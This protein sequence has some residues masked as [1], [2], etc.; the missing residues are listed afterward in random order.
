[1]II[2]IIIKIQQ[3]EILNPDEKKKYWLAEE[4]EQIDQALWISGLSIDPEKLEPSLSFVM[5]TYDC[6]N[7][8]PHDIIIIKK[9]QEKIFFW[10]YLYFVV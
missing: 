1:M 7:I 9:M 10:T 5:V 8:I 3:A 2:I 4:R 6:G